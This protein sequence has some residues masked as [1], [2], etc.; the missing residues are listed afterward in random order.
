VLVVLFLAKVI[1]SNQL[2]TSGAKLRNLETRIA[3]LE[4]ANRKLNQ[5]I[6]EKTSLGYL[7]EK[8][9]EFNLYAQ[10]EMVKLT[11]PASLAMS[12]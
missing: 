9:L 12:E 10:P 8:A 4:D 1:V 2:A 11:G 6:T 7:S 5:Q 3:E